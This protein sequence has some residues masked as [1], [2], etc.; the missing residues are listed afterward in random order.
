[1]L[2]FGVQSLLLQQW[3]CSMPPSSIIAVSAAATAVET[4][5]RKRNQSNFVFAVVALRYLWSSW[6]CKWSTCTCSSAKLLLKV[7]DGK[8]WGNWWSGG[9]DLIL[10][11]RS[12]LVCVLCIMALI[13]YLY[14]LY[15]I[16]LSEVY[17][18]QRGDASFG[19]DIKPL[20]LQGPGLI[21][22]PG[23]WSTTIV[24]N[25]IGYIQNIDS[26]LW[27]T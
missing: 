9:Q 23:L 16:A 8:G 2:G 5:Q 14:Y 12:C 17:P 7:S 15:Y 24:L 11:K 25:Q 19:G 27:L 21:S 6:C 1:M 26:S 18:S 20:V 13:V 4:E 22:I 3:H 10:L